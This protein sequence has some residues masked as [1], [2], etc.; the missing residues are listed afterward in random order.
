MQVVSLSRSDGDG[1]E[2]A[3]RWATRVTTA[4]FPQV[5]EPFAAESFQIQEGTG[6]ARGGAAEEPVTKR[7]RWRHP[8][9]QGQRTQA[10]SSAACAA[11]RSP[12]ALTSLRFSHQAP[13][14]LGASQLAAFNY[15][16]IF[17]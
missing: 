5:S 2:G 8:E 9:G 15:N 11:A 16:F 10:P 12:R 4:E 1:A 17:N 13:I 14:Q 3:E 7:R 6:I